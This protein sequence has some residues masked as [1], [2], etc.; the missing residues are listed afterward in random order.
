MVTVVSFEP[1]TREFSPV[2]APPA[3]RAEPELSL[4]ALHLRVRQQE[5]LSDFGVL[6]LKKASHF[7][8]CSVTQLTWWRRGSK[9]SSRKS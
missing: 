6:A 1:S 8:N 5:M 2:E 3:G 9:Q 4:E 7:R